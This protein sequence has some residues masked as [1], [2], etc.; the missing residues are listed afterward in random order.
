MFLF[1]SPSREIYYVAMSQYG[2]IVTNVADLRAEP[3]FTAERVSQALFA[4]LLVYRAVRKGFTRVKLTSGYAGWVDS[5]L[6]TNL[7]QKD[8]K[9]YQRLTKQVVISRQARLFTKSGKPI[10]PYFVYYATKL[11]VQKVRNN[12]ACVLLPDKTT[13][14]IKAGNLS[15][16]DKRNRQLVSG[17]ALIKEAKRFLGT[18][19]L[20]GG[21]TPAGYDCSG[22]VQAVCSRFGISI[23]RDTK[24][25]IQYGETIGRSAV[26]T[27]D[28]L[29]FNRHVGFAVGKDKIIHASRAAGGV[30]LESL[31]AG[32]PEYRKDLDREFVIARRLV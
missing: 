14:Y 22:F 28:L 11:P 32:D 13:V 2:W 7:T 16:I 21:T 29:F 27:G 17:A 15:P 3:S 25:Q 23:P 30:R 19:Y 5:R 31:Q 4:E 24:E 18:P 26:K 8:F 20:W 12:T 6:I 10:S 9:Q 1:D